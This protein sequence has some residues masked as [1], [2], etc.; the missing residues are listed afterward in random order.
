MSFKVLFHTFLIIFL[1]NQCQGQP[2]VIV[3]QTDD[4]R[5]YMVSFRRANHTVWISCAGVFI[6]ETHVLT[7]ATCLENHNIVPPLLMSSG[8]T[9]VYTESLYGTS[10][11]VYKI[12]VHPGFNTSRLMQYNIAVVEVTGS[13]HHKKQF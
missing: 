6:T 5:L 4:A 12:H 7:A 11:S 1:A 8:Q 2:N 13:N 9:T 3:E 10:H